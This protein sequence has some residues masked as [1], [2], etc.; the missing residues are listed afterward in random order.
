VEN[1]V[2]PQSSGL[3]GERVVCIAWESV[4]LR[5]KLHGIGNI[6]K[7]LD[8]KLKYNSF[9]P[10]SI[11]VGLVVDKVA[12]GQ[13]FTQVLQFC[14]VSFIPPVLHYLGKWK[15]LTISLFGFITR[16]VQ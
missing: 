15:K 6:Q 1:S 12:L 16:V 4:S 8:S 13:V 5:G 14:P 7:I 2:F 11:H 10:G 9:N 3:Y